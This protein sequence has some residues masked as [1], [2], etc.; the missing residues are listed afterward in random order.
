M[1]THFGRYELLQKLAAGGMG[2]VWLARQQTAQGLG[3][4][5]VLK[6]VLPH[7]VERPEIGA[8]FLDEAR[9]ALG[10]SHPNLAQVCDAG[11]VN[12]TK[13]LAM[14]FVHG[15]DLRQVLDRL[16][17][18][19]ERMPPG[20]AVRVAADAA[21]ALACAHEAKDEAGR[22]LNLVHRDVSPQNVMLGFDGAV[23]VIDF[24]VARSAA[25]RVQTAAGLVKGKFGYVAP[26]QARSQPVDGRTDLFALG[27]VLHE[28][29]S[30][31]SLF[32]RES[33]AS[34]L[35]ALLEARVPALVPSTPGVDLEL[36]AMVL[37]ALQPDPAQRF[38]SA[39]E[40][41]LALED[42]LIARRAP[43]S[44]AHLAAWLRQLFPDR[45]EDPFLGT[46]SPVVP[47]PQPAAQLELEQSE[48]MPAG[49]AMGADGLLDAPLPDSPKH[50][51]PAPAAPV[52]TAPVRAAEVEVLELDSEKLA[53]ATAREFMAE[54]A[55]PKS[56]REEVKPKKRFLPFVLVL[57]VLFAAGGVAV[58]WL[59]QSKDPVAQLSGSVSKVAE[60]GAVKDLPQK[61]TSAGTEVVKELPGTIAKVAD[62]DVT[63]LPG[64]LAKAVKGEPK[65]LSVDSVPSGAEIWL[66]SELLGTTP[67]IGTNDYP[68]G[69]YRLKL[70]RGGY[71]TAEVTFTA[72]RETR[73]KVPLKK[74]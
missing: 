61:L 65:L 56:Y 2:E 5:V 45:L 46:P 44:S 64:V 31:A 59:Q 21:A 42:W 27:I 17:Q 52:P 51:A 58:A 69:E 28:A 35:N 47:A 34:T 22:P 67:F 19:G 57:L 1:A 3:K 16:A 74:R 24:G 32:L 38:Q 8:M 6:L 29:L 68:D 71:R 53:H 20:L 14:E 37:R 72:G 60:A 55:E 15:V 41:R 40:L 9:V 4:R 49:P 43:A 33:E 30:G 18:R 36:Q 73:L 39:A 26:E 7:L 12:G 23:K 50:R 25:N 13:Y 10:L 54:S 11:E 66:G 70:V 48:W 63:A 62:T